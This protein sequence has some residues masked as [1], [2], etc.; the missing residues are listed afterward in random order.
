MWQQN[1]LKDSIFVKWN[2]HRQIVPGPAVDTAC[3]LRESFMVYISPCTVGTH[4]ANTNTIFSENQ[5]LFRPSATLKSH[6][7]I[8]LYTAGCFLAWLYLLIYLFT[9]QK[10]VLWCQDAGNCPDC[11]VLLKLHDLFTDIHLHF[12]LLQP[13][14]DS[15][16]LLSSRLSPTDEWSQP[17]LLNILQ[18]YLGIETKLKVPRSPK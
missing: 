16:S 7:L 1:I 18:G 10:T 13:V 8:I 12:W 2:H 15:Q 14:I 3:S 6:G 17:G 11:W 9:K 4:K 5:S